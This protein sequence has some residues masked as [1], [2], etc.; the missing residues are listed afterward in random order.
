[1]AAFFFLSSRASVNAVTK[2]GTND[3]HGTVYG[4]YR[5]EDMTGR[6]IKGDKLAKAE[7]S[8]SQYG[9]SIGGPLVK[10]KL[11]FFANFEKDDRDDLGQNWLPQE[12]G[13]VNA[14]RVRESDLIAVQNALLGLGYNPGS[15]KGF[16]H[17]SESQKGIV[18]FV[19]KGTKEN[20]IT[21]KVGDTVLYS[22]YG[23][24]ELQFQGEDF[25]SIYC[26]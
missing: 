23:G 12:S 7:L 24:T 19:G 4:F 8:Q 1:M 5:N 18:K 25:L 14:S 10:N 3:F 11:F 15:Y 6:K 21:L 9:L 20:P 2:S 22:K 13:G 17:K 16:L 26:F